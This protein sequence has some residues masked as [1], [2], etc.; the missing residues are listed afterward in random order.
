MEEKSFWVN[1]SYCGALLKTPGNSK[2]GVN[3]EFT[4]P[5]ICKP[6]DVQTI[7]SAIGKGYLGDCIVVYDTPNFDKKTKEYLV[8]KD[9]M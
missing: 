6:K 4:I 7:A 2:Y 5:I 8:V 9:C 1:V 3:A